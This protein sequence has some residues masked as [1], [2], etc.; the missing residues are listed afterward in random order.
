M[1]FPKSIR[2]KVITYLD[3]LIE[4]GYNFEYEIKSIHSINSM[5]IITSG[6][7]EYPKIYIGSRI[8]NGENCNDIPMVKHYVKI[9]YSEEYF[10][11]ESDLSIL[12]EELLDNILEK[13]NEIGV[14]FHGDPILK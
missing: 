9:I 10:I 6:I 3:D 12:T 11:L 5:I 14:E 13:I 4:K 1:S 2:Y 7:N 8:I